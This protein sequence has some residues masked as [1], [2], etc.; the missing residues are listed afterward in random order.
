MESDYEDCSPLTIVTEIIDWA[1]PPDSNDIILDSDIPTFTEEV[2]TND[3]IITEELEEEEFVDETPP[4]LPPPQ[5]ELIKLNKINPRSLLKNNVN[6]K[7]PECKFK[8]TLTVNSSLLKSKQ[9]LLKNTRIADIVV[10]QKIPEINK[11][12]EVI[13][14]PKFKQTVK[15]VRNNVLLDKRLKA[16]GKKK[17]VRIKK[18]PVLKKPRKKSVVLDD[19]ITI[20]HEDTESTNNSFIS[21]NMS[22]IGYKTTKNDSD[23]DI[24][25]DIE[26]DQSQEDENELIKP[27]ARMEVKIPTILPKPIKEE[28]EE[29]DEEQVENLH[30]ENSSKD[31]SQCSEKL[32]EIL[33]DSNDPIEEVKLNPTEI[34]ELEMFIHSEF[35]EGR[36]TKTP[37]RYVKIRN[38]I[39]SSWDI[40]KPAYIS[41]TAIRNGLKN[42]GDVNC[43]SRIHCLLEQIGAI[44]FGC[45]GEYFNYIRPLSRLMDSFVQQPRNNR[46]PP[47]TSS[48]LVINMK[49]RQRIKSHN[50]SNMSL[51]SDGNCTIPHQDRLKKSPTVAD[52]SKN[53]TNWRHE[54]ELVKCKRFS[55]ENIAPFKVSITLSTLLCL[56]LHSLSSNYEVMGF[57]GG[58]RSKTIGRTKICLARYKP[59]KTAKQSGTMCEMCPVS[60]VE[61]SL[62]LLNEGYDLLGWFHS[63]PLFPPNPSRTDVNTQAEMQMQFCTDREKPFIGFILGCVDMQYK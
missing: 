33:E 35:F 17:P 39:L 44:N 50:Y 8:Q 3:Y 26:T 16:F 21:S 59:C 12:V 24:E 57:L 54:F 36:L 45:Q 23:S 7:K 62:G 61:Q 2:V 48:S 4:P 9:S 40:S 47:G 46:M 34:T 43:I 31:L 5:K 63:H 52:K 10:K 29:L 15:I 19:N 58:Y 22:E 14:K 42:C 32:R 13:V 51:D 60:Q 37:D 49:R 6:F 56:Q 25:I 53:L 18:T 55:K 1:P 27:V 20:S 30:Y 41:K 11:K 28:F 38:H